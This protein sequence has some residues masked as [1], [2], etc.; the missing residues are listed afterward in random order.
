MFFTLG[1]HTNFY[2]YSWLSDVANH[3]LGGSSRKARAPCNRDA[4]V[5]NRHDNSECIAKCA[6]SLYTNFGVAY[7]SC[8][9]MLLVSSLYYHDHDEPHTVVYLQ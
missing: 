1:A 3:E 5:T 7:D 2:N 9:L 8:I 4:H 6:A